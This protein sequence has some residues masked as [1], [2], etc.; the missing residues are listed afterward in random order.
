[1][2][3]DAITRSSVVWANS[4]TQRTSS[5]S[6]PSASPTSRTASP[7]MAVPL[8][9]IAGRSGWSMGWPKPTG[10]SVSGES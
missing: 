7:K 10:F 4:A 1:M 9:A 5:S 6:T 3:Q 2:V 8:A